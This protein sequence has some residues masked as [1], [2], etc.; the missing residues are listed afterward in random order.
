MCLGYIRNRIGMLSPGLL[1]ALPT[2]AQVPTEHHRT[3]PAT[4]QFVSPKCCWFLSTLFYV[5]EPGW[6]DND[7][8]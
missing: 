4:H 1:Q 7:T 5:T 8:L 6:V 2:L 3:S